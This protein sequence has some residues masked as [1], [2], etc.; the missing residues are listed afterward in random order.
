MPILLAPGNTILN[1]V[2]ILRPG[3]LVIFLHLARWAERDGFGGLKGIRVDTRWCKLAGARPI[4]R[5]RSV[6][7]QG[8]TNQ[9]NI[10]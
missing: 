4:M 3:L 10:I 9:M 1:L 2:N 7:F 5:S 6:P 8:M